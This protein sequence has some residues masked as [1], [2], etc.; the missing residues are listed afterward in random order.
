M[1][2]NYNAYFGFLIIPYKKKTC[3]M[4]CRCTTFLAGMDL[5]AVKGDDCLY[6]I[7]CKSETEF[8]RM[9]YTCI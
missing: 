4:A 9:L 1:K 3:D 2:E 7:T 8:N 6:Q 5:G